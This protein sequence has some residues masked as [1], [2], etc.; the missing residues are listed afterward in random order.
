MTYQAIPSIQLINAM[1]QLAALRQRDHVAYQPPLP[2]AV[3]DRAWIAQ[4]APPKPATSHQL[5][6]TPSA[7]APN[8]DH[9][10][11]I[12]I[13][14]LRAGQSSHYQM[15][16]VMRLLDK[17]GAGRVSLDTLKLHTTNGF[18]KHF[19]YNGPRLRQ[20]LAE[21]DGRYWTLPSS[22]CVRAHIYY[23]ATHRLAY[24]LGLTRLTGRFVT[25]TADQAKSSQATFRAHC[26]AAWLANRGNPI[27]Q[28]A[29]QRLTGIHPRSQRR[30]VELAHIRVNRNIAIGP[31]FTPDTAQE[32]AWQRGTALF[33]FT[34][35]RGRQGPAGRK[36]C[37][38]H[39]PNGYEGPARGTRSQQRSTNKR[40]QATL[41]KN[42]ARG[43]GQAVV[44]EQ[45]YRRLFYENGARAGQAIGRQAGQ[46]NDVYW[47]GMQ[48]RTGTSLWYSAGGQT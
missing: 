15:W 7:F 4:L 26:F 44:N 5:P 23:T 34:D 6:A 1:R 19:L 3:P 18:S 12:A 14:A 48:A 16:L 31:R 36:Y 33:D 32:Q 39:L 21:G 8:I 30:Y 20:I 22:T 2:A 24:N 41:V 45:A 27:T 29:I 35:H 46:D 25:I 40:L 43:N 17:D 11:D 10:G 38:W 28:E 13:A 42:G 37:A 9:H 47:R